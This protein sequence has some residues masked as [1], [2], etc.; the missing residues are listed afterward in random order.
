MFK[1]IKAAFWVR[2][3][4][5]LLGAVPIN[6]IVLPLILAFS[7]LHP[8]FL[9]IGIGFECALISV[10]AFNA[11][12]RKWVDSPSLEK[13]QQEKKQRQAN[14]LNKLTP[15]DQQRFKQ[16]QERVQK[17]KKSYID[18]DAP[19]YIAEPN[20]RNLDSLLETLLKL[21]FAKESLEGEEGERNTY[22]VKADLE[23]L[24][25]ELNDATLNKSVRESKEATRD[26]LQKRLSH[27]DKRQESIQEIEANLHRI[28]AQIELAHDNTRL[29]AKPEAINIDIDFASDSMQSVWYMEE[30]S[31]H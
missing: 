2:Q 7:F 31:T 30:P 11:H 27:L 5:P 24:E 23:A 21:L 28:E 3:S 26:I 17:I 22:R 6:L 9:L 20:K 12:F 8:A 15:P 13:L 10:L 29:Q 16:V 18:F 14:L 19:D 4:I 1:Y 25:E